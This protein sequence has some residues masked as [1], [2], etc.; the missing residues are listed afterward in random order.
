MIVESV[1]S[2]LQVFPLK[3]IRLRHSPLSTI[4]YFHTLSGVKSKKQKLH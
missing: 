3:K 2:D 4:N 1:A